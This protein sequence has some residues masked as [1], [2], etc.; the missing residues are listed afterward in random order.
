MN[1]KM[2]QIVE[3]LEL[4]DSVEVLLFDE[5]QSIVSVR[6]IDQQSQWKKDLLYIGYAN[7][8]DIEENPPHAGNFLIL[9]L[10]AEQPMLLKRIQKVSCGNWCL[11]SCSGAYYEL[12]NR[13]Q[14]ILMDFQAIIQDSAVLLHSIIQGRGL[15][16]I[17]E[18]AGE[19]LGNPVM[20]GD[21]NHRL[22][23]YSRCDDVAD[24]AWNEFRDTGYC[25]YDYTVKYNFKPWIEKT[26]CS[27]GPVIG[28]LGEVSRLNRIFATVHIGE[29]IV[30]H[31]AV[32]EYRR[33]F[34]EKDLETVLFICRLIASE[35]QGNPRYLN[36]R[37]VILE[38][39]LLDLFNGSYADMSKV[40]E[41]IKQINWTVPAKMHVMVIPYN[42]YED[43][44][45]LIPYIRESLKELS[46]GE[47]V[48][49]KNKLAFILGYEKD[50]YFKMQDIRELEAF[51][52]DNQ[53]KAGVSQEFY[54]LLELKHRF[55]QADQAIPLGKKLGR[56]Q[57]VY[58][59]EDYGIY[60]MLQVL[61]TSHSIQDFCHPLVL[62]L[63]EYDRRHKTEYLKTLYTF[64]TH[65]R[66]LAATAEAL[67]IHRNTLAYRLSKIQELL[68]SQLEDKDLSMKIF[69]SYKILEY[70]NRL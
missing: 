59:Y 44:F 51:L 27:E 20:L 55:E 23:G 15:A 58:L 56:E 47:V 64:M 8:L 42:S 12:F 46:A 28:S 33:P 62:K 34:M 10:E 70:T 25:T 36:S 66:S 17:M 7:Q 1:P 26:A 68:G 35:M 3:R 18:I 13:V 54:D 43:S 65:L 14:E 19:L 9:C 21:N 52:Q 30:G 11:L 61:E 22:L 32:L 31:L 48:F 16:Y 6:L 45:S 38:K 2:M 24:S 40:R 4:A 29:S 60:H 49:F 5:E 69:V 50:R 57:A 53:L 41:R 67:F 39:L 37:N 63:Q